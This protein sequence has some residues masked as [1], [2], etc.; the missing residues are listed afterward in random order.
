[1][2]DTQGQVEQNQ[3]FQRKFADFLRHSKSLQHIDLSG[4]GFSEDTL[5]YITLNGIRKSKTLLAIHMAGCFGYYGL[6]VK[7]RE[8]LKVSQVFRENSQDMLVKQDTELLSPTVPDDHH[9]KT[10]KQRDH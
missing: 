6:L 8:W 5:Q 4:L 10:K 1:M 2:S 3:E 7:M 9:K